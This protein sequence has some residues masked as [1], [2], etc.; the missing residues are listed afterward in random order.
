MAKRIIFLLLATAAVGCNRG[1]AGR[2][3]PTPKQKT[4]QTE[5]APA[6]ATPSAPL[7]A[8]AARARDAIPT[9][10]P[11]NT[12][13]QRLTGHIKLEV[14]GQ[15][16]P[17]VIRLATRGERTR[18]DIDRSKTQKP[19]S[20][21]LTDDD[22]IVLDDTARTYSTSAWRDVAPRQER[23]TDVKVERTSERRLV[24]GLW[25]SVWHLTLEPQNVEACVRAA[26]AKL[27]PDRLE[28]LAKLD[29]PM[30]AELMLEDGYLPLQATVRD[31]T[32]EL[33]RVELTEY[34]REQASE[35]EI[36]APT[37]YKELK[38]RG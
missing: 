1:D 28:T 20:L 19:V 16:E 14:K 18:I 17:L 31:G 27:D 33:Y 15:G 6:A 32:R 24:T 26:P 25:C 35:R 10:A 7:N 37:T 13:L 36:A 2:A 38:P 12:P 9:D 29:L 4:T 5:P 8:E 21:L 22:A 11:D 30:W 34:S 23:E 3:E